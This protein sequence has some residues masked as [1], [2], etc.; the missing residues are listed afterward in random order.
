MAERQL[1]DRH[2]ILKQPPPRSLFTE[3][4]TKPRR[5]EAFVLYDSKPIVQEYF[6]AIREQ[7]VATA[8]VVET[9]TFIDSELK[10]L[11]LR[12]GRL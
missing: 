10:R 5:D 1:P 12:K 7:Q 6:R 3:T 11:L 4:C 9:T 2:N 8:V